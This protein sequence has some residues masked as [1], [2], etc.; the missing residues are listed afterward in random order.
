M[1]L[2]FYCSNSFK[3]EYTKLIKK[4]SYNDLEPALIDF[5]GIDKKNI[6]DFFEG[7]KLNGN[8]DADPSLIKKRLLG[9]SGYRLYYYLYIVKNKIYFISIHP[10]TGK[11][12]K[13]N[14]EDIKEIKK[15]FKI[16]LQN[17]DVFK[18]S[19]ENKKIVFK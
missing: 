7:T 5:L 10:K 16:D 19:V 17:N 12:G 13:A 18:I 4:K 3:D 9:S 14:E 11:R 6:Q 2:T 1:A 15:Q 8:V